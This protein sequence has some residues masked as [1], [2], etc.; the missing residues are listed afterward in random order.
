L[1]NLPD[2]SI[3]LLYIDDLHTHDAVKTDFE[4]GRRKLSARAVVLFHDTVETPRDF[5]VY[6]LWA[7][8]SPNFPSF[9]F[10]HGLGIL[11]VGPQQPPAFLEFLH[12]ANAK[13]AAT[14]ALF[15]A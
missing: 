12:T 10:E 9:N 8:L 4:T 2:A 1:P 5:G 6:R 3:D 13:P 15:A 11:A 14:H 7:G